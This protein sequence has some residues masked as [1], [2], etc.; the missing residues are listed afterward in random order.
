[1]TWKLLLDR[2]RRGIA[3]VTGTLLVGGTYGTLAA[4]AAKVLLDLAEKD[5]WL[6]VGLPVALVLGV[7]I[8]PKIGRI[9]GF[10]K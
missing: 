2:V 3:I 1:M 7:F 10:D 4:M 8:W 5:A 9:L 6:F